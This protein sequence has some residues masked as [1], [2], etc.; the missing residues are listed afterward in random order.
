MFTIGV[1]DSRTLSSVG[2]LLNRCIH[3]CVSLYAHN[4]FV[5]FIS[6]LYHLTFNGFLSS[7]VVLETRDLVSRRL[8][9]KNES[10]DIGLEDLIL[11][12]IVVLK[13]V[14]ITSL[15]LRLFMSFN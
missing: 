1:V 8:E 4:Q 2:M 7:D 9:D 12:F 13:K 10:L 5:C 14:L 11:L 6:M 15:L 3:Y